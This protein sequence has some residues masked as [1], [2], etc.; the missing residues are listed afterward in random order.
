MY[1]IMLS[2]YHYIVKL[3]LEK[4]SSKCTVICIFDIPFVCAGLPQL[5]HVLVPRTRA[6]ELCVE[7]LRQNTAAIYDLTIGYCNT[8]DG[9]SGARLQ[10]PSLPGRIIFEKFHS[11][12]CSSATMVILVQ[13]MYFDHLSV[14]F[15]L[16]A[17]FQPPS[18]LA[19]EAHG[20]E[21]G[22]F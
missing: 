22:P 14:C 12:N 5:K 17:K 3:I 6:F 20:H 1:T 11:N 13:T 16:F 9:V 4:W 21:P 10:A 15:R 19:L 18:A 2:F 8:I 7:H